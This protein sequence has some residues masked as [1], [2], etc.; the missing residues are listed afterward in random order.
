MLVVEA[1]GLDLCVEIPETDITL[2]NIRYVTDSNFPLTALVFPGECIQV[3]IVGD[4]QHFPPAI[5]SDIASEL[6]AVVNDLAGQQFLSLGQLMYNQSLRMKAQYVQTELSNTQPYALIDEWICHASKN[7][8]TDIAVIDKG[9]EYSYSRL[10]QSAYAISGVIEDHRCESAYIGI[11]LERGFNQIA[12]ILAVLFCGKAYVP[13]DSNW[14]DS[15]IEK[16]IKD[17]EITLVLTNG[18]TVQGKNVWANQVESV[19]LATIELSCE[20]A[21]CKDSGLGQSVGRVEKYHLSVAGKRDRAADDAAYM[22]YTSG[23]TGQPKGVSISH[24]NLVYSTAARLAYYKTPPERYLLLSTFSFDSSV[25]GIFWTLCSGGTLV[26]PGASQAQD[27]HAIEHHIASHAITHTLCLPSLYTLLLRY[28]AID[29]LRTL[30]SVIVAGEACPPM[31]TSLHS[32]QLPGTKLFNEY[33]PTEGTVWSTVAELTKDHTLADNAPI[34]QAIPGTAVQV[35]DSLGRVCPVGVAG[36]L[37][38]TGQGVASG[39]HGNE[40]LA[41][42]KFEKIECSGRDLS[43]VHSYRTGDLTVLGSCLLYTSPSPRDRQKS[44]MPSS[45]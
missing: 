35:I 11:Y 8:D 39:Y 27:I 23:S 30:N 14:P 3:Q 20:S 37:L 13:L 24:A 26:L 43:S 2:S 7:P 4:T 32:Q 41:D 33:G 38:L 36:E 6:V 42:S 10:I 17:A 16:I 19:D 28:A 5:L 45:A 1:H 29:N 22:I 12:A 9:S 18:R 40:A 31:L 21:N 44:R 25:A 15:R 34:G